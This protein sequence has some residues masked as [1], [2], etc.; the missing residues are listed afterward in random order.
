MN[1]SLYQ[2]IDRTFPHTESSWEGTNERKYAFNEVD[3]SNRFDKKYS[4][5]CFDVGMNFTNQHYYWNQTISQNLNGLLNGPNLYPDTQLLYPQ[6]PVSYDQFP[7]S[8][9]Y[10]DASG[11]HW[12]SSHCYF[13]NNSSVF[14]GNGSISKWFSL[15]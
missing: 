8:L 13:D 3:Y 6:T 1:H 5:P 11:N 15:V 4:G 12:H 7:T 9:D 10:A 14:P 2:S